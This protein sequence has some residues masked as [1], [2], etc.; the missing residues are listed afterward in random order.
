M[1]SLVVRSPWLQAW[2][3]KAR[4]T[5]LVV[6][7]TLIVNKIIWL[8]HCAAALLGRSTLLN[9]FWSILHLLFEIEESKGRNL[10][11]GRADGAWAP[12]EFG[13][14]ER[15]TEREIDN[16]LIKAPGFKILTRSL[17]ERCLMYF[18]TYL[19]DTAMVTNALS[20]YRSKSS[21]TG[22]IFFGLVQ[23]ILDKSKLY[24][25]ELFFII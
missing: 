15:K 22:P 19:S 3:S 23:I 18:N 5:S 6:F 12:L 17:N 20:V 10:V 24:V 13:G 16:L 21:W 7:G 4:C 11:G 9:V 2:H 8:F 25:Y 1:P 14:A